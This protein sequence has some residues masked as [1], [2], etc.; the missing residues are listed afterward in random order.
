[1]WDVNNLK[2]IDEFENLDY[3]VLLKISEMLN[4]YED[5][6]SDNNELKNDISS[7]EDEIE[8]LES[9]IEDL[10]DDKSKLSD[11]LQECYEVGNQKFPKCRRSSAIPRANARFP[12]RQSA[13]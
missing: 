13:A 2:R 5:I 4:K 11:L 9:D 1:M 7:Y 3:W 8:S 12:R 10:E 6:C